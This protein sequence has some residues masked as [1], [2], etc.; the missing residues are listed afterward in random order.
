MT[1]G[2]ASTQLDF[3]FYEFDPPVQ[4]EFNDPFTENQDGSLDF[5]LTGNL[6]VEKNAE[7]KQDVEILGIL[8]V[9]TTDIL[10]E[11]EDLKN[12]VQNIKILLGI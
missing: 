3:K 7:F 9:G 10:Q 5:N 12:D 6:T 4:E 2:V 8:T 1:A 11:I